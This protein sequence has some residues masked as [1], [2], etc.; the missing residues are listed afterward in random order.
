M[1]HYLSIYLSISIYIYLSGLYLDV[2]YIS[3]L[4]LDVTYISGLYLD[5]TY[6]SGLYLDVTYISGLYLDVTY[7][8]GLYLDVTYI[9]G[10]YLDVTYISGSFLDVTY[11]SG[12]YLDI[13]CQTIFSMGIF[14]H[15]EKETNMVH[16]LHIETSKLRRTLGGRWLQL[17]WVLPGDGPPWTDLRLRDL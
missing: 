10:L 1:L 4:Y 2:T 13:F 5:V 7:I 14:R 3:G 16:T 8:S 9:S 15:L 17:V 11:I 6:I 12:L